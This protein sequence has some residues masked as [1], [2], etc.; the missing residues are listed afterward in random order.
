M[1]PTAR[2]LDTADRDEAI[3]AENLA[4]AHASAEPSTRPAAISWPRYLLVT[5]IG[6]IG[7]VALLVS[8]AYV[9]PLANPLRL[10]ALIWFFA[11]G[12]VRVIYLGRRR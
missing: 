4:A 1:A 6:V 9:P 11:F 7:F 8:S 10:I 5:L 3:V 2:R 12:A